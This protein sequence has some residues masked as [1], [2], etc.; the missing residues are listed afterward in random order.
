MEYNAD[1]YDVDYDRCDTR[2]EVQRLF[3]SLAVDIS[4]IDELDC[5]INTEKR[6]DYAVPIVKLM[7]DCNLRW[8]GFGSDFVNAAGDIVY[9]DPSFHELGPRTALIREDVLEQYLIANNLELCWVVMGEKMSI[10]GGGRSPSSF[11]KFHGC[12]YFNRHN[13]Q[14]IRGNLLSYVPDYSKDS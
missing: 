13:K 7:R 5:S 9:T 2:R 4:G 6:I 8:S 11:L 10:I 1:D 12:Y 3:K 14:Q